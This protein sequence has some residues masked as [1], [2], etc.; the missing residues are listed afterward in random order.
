MT[1]NV[2]EEIMKIKA[3]YNFNY[4]RMLEFLF[5]E[6]KFSPLAMPQSV[7]M[8]RKSKKVFEELKSFEIYEELM[9]EFRI[10]DQE[11]LIQSMQVRAEVFDRPGKDPKILNVGTIIKKVTNDLYAILK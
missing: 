10:E 11:K 4:T 6:L 2:D 3:I 5:H 7:D 8:V 9:H 1:W